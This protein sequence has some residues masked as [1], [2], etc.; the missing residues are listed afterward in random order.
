MDAKR[1][2]MCLPEERK[3]VQRGVAGKRKEKKKNSRAGPHIIIIFL[4]P[5]IYEKGDGL[6]G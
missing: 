5:P 1:A 4:L 2:T 3:Y 6:M